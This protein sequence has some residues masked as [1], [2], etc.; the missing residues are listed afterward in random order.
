MSCFRYAWQSFCQY[1]GFREHTQVWCGD[2]ASFLY[3]SIQ[4][5][6][7]QIAW[8]CKYMSYSVLRC[9]SA[10]FGYLYRSDLSHFLTTNGYHCTGVAFKLGKPIGAKTVNLEW[11]KSSDR[12]CKFIPSQ[13][14]DHISSS[15]STT[16]SW[17]SR[18][19]EASREGLLAKIVQTS[20]TFQRPR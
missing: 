2:Q 12:L 11:P 19:S 20:C 5:C 14:P 18:F 10:L 4:G 17:W 1:V 3:R 15:R 8:H 9:L 7:W 13:S 16:L 6:S